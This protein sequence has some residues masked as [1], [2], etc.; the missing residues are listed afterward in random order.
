MRLVFMGTPEFAVRSLDILNANRYEIAAVV[1]APDKPR[2]R[3]RQVSFTP[4]KTYALEHGLP[5][6]QPEKL[7]DLQFAESLKTLEPDVIAV[8]AFRIL[9][10][11][12]F[13]LPKKGSFNL[14]ASLLPKYRGAAPINWAL[15]KGEKET[16]VTSFLLQEKVDTG[17]IL[18]QE[19]ISIGEN[20]TAGELH[21]RLAV[22][23]ADVVL[24]TVR[25]IESGKAQPSVQEEALASPAPK[26]FKEDCR[27]PWQQPSQTVHNFIRGLSPHPCAWTTHRG[28]TLRIYRA[29]PE[30]G[31]AGVPG[32]VVSV[33]KEKLLVGTGN[34]IIAV[35][36]IQQEGKRRLGIEEFLR[37][38]SFAEGDLFL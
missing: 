9:P 34:G 22:L 38:Y 3:G 10:R 1:T 33:T 13:L 29:S 26:I 2:G 15:L 30:A 27:I 32:S 31:N 4:V 35:Q 19:K 21:D 17:S 25:L 20:E 11:E 37:G 18:L 8:V 16:G 12:I 14:H 7:N 23:G 24:R 28:T 36:E 5:C 6:L